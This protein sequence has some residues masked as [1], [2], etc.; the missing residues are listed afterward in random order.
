MSHSDKCYEYI[1]ANPGIEAI[2]IPSRWRSA[3]RE[4]EKAERIRYHHEGWYA[5][6]DAP[7]AVEAASAKSPDEVFE[8]ML[9]DRDWG[10]Q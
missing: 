4:L 2:N 6:A 8:P 9:P 1:K 7:E 3:L 10:L 5:N